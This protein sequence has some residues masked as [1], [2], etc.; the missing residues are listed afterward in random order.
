MEFSDFVKYFTEICICRIINTSFFSLSKTWSESSDYG[1]WCGSNERAGGCPNN[2]T[3]LKN[4]QYTFDV[5]SSEM[6]EETLI[7]LD[8][9]SLRYLGKENLTFG[10]TLMKVEENRIY[11]LNL[12]QEKVFTSS[13]INTRSICMRKKL[14]AGRY[15]IVPSTYQ[16]NTEG[17]FLLRIYTENHCNLR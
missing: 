12:E 4:P 5:V 16:P 1:R 13:F 10:F 17:E 6:Q 2:R 14:V 11:R 3:F 15:C 7:N 9:K 8:Q